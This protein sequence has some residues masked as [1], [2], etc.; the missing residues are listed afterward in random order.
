ML[1]DKE[2]EVFLK[3]AGWIYQSNGNFWYYPK[4]YSLLDPRDGT[5]CLDIAY[6]VETTGYLR[7]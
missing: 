5:F 6:E 4:T 2:K 3:L 1:N 7:V